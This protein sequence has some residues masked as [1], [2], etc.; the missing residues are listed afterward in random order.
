MEHP[1]VLAT[2]VW[3]EESAEVFGYLLVAFSGLEAVIEA[4][5]RRAKE[6]IALPLND[7]NPT[8]ASARRA[9]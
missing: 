6:S 9:A 4:F 8:E 7:A 1:N 2:K 5:G 3:V